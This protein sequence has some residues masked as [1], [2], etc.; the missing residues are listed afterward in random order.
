MR[1][2]FYA[3]ALCSTLGLCAAAD[4]NFALE[5]LGNTLAQSQSKAMYD[6]FVFMIRQLQDMACSTQANLDQVKEILTQQLEQF[7]NIPND[8][9]EEA[10]MMRHAL[11]IFKKALAAVAEVTRKNALPAVDSEIFK[12]GVDAQVTRLKVIEY[13]ESMLK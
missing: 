1:H 5:T 10:Y 13:I 12:K 4:N 9:S 7:K 6:Q 2:L 3:T 8:N 11:G